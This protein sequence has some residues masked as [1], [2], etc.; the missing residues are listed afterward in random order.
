MG[1]FVSRINQ[2]GKNL[3][4]LDAIYYVDTVWKFVKST[5]VK[6]PRRD[7]LSD[8][9]KEI[10]TEEDDSTEKESETLKDMKKLNFLQ[11]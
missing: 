2:D 6:K 8:E 11:N 7:F 9:K 4:I 1:L 3:T 10:S 5:A